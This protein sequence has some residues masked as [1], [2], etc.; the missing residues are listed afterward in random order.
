[1]KCKKLKYKSLFACE[2]RLFV[3]LLHMHGVRSQSLKL[4]GAKN[5]RNMTEN[6]QIFTDNHSKC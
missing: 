6:V 5:T 4:P 1:M 3:S 2:V